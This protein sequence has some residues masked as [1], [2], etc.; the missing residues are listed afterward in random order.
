MPALQFATATANLASQNAF[1]FLATHGPIIGPIIRESGLP[2]CLPLPGDPRSNYRS[3]YTP[4]GR[5]RQTTGWTHC[6]IA[7]LLDAEGQEL[8]V[9]CHI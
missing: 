6:P 2:K 4:P 3:N 8:L 1:L 5:R 7:G 9:V